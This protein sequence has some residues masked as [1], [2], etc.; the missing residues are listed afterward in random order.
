VHFFKI[1]FNIIF[2]SSPRSPKWSLAT[3]NVSKI[4]N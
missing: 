4:L 2:S 1:H 3:K